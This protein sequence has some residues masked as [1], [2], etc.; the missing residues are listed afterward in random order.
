VEPVADAP[1]VDQA[2]GGDHPQAIARMLE[3]ISMAVR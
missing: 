1:G 3:R 2:G